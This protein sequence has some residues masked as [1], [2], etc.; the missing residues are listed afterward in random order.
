MRRFHIHTVNF[1]NI[2]VLLLVMTFPVQAAYLSA[3]PKENSHTV[4]PSY[5]RV[6]DPYQQFK[7]GIIAYE[8]AN[9]VSAVN[10]FAEL[11]KAGYMNAQFYLAI[12]LDSGS[13]VE[14]D[15]MQ[16]A[17]WYMKA[18]AK[19]HVEAQYNLS[20]AYASGEGVVQ[21]MQKS[22]YWMK[23]AALNGSVNSQYNLGLIYIFGDGVEINLEE[24][25]LWWRLAAKNG[26]VMAQ[27]NLGMIYL[28]GRGV[29]SDICEATRWWQISAEN[30][31]SNSRIAL[32]TLKETQATKGCVGMISSR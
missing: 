26:D 8:S 14:E 11:A 17:L 16:A 21:D 18:A 6:T 3:T 20:M 28:E 12:M 13:G 23:K 22:I 2:P 25:I 15:H 31:H 5:Q 1:W 24:G 19:G 30:G 29:E 7:L 27:F 9:Y 4:T 32:K 10:I